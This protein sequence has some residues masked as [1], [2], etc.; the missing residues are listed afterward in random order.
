MLNCGYDIHHPRTRVDNLQH[1][2]PVQILNQISFFSHL[3]FRFVLLY[4]EVGPHQMGGK[5]YL[6]QLI[7]LPSSDNR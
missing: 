6:V 3:R 7:F 5:K 2:Q 4:M 1:Q